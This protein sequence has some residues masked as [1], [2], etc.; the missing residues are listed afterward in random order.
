MVGSYSF[1]RSASMPIGV[2]VRLNLILLLV[3]TA[4]EA[5]RLVNF[6]DYR[7]VGKRGGNSTS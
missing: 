4:A 5:G 7:R 2:L 3:F 1:S 6:Q